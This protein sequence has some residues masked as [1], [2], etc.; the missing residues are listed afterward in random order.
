MIFAR[1]YEVIHSQYKLPAANLLAAQKHMHIM[2]Q[3]VVAGQMIDVDNMNG[4]HVDLV[5][6]EAK[7]HYKSGQYSFTRPLVT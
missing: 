3:E 7:N 1:A 2:I 5:K 4:D 6:L